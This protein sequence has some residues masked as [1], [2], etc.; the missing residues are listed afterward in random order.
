MKPGSISFF[1]TSLWLAIC[2]REYVTLTGLPSLSFPSYETWPVF[3]S[4]TQERDNFS[5]STLK[6][7]LNVYRT[8]SICSHESRP[9][10]LAIWSAIAGRCCA[11]AGAE[12]TAPANRT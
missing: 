12:Q 8:A 1:T 10:A 6:S 3:G 9:Y 11:D 4:H 2:E 5:F 7:M